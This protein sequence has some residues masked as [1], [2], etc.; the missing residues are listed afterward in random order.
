MNRTLQ[1]GLLALLLAGCTSGWTPGDGRQYFKWRRKGTMP[2]TEPTAIADDDPRLAL[3]W[4]PPKDRPADGSIAPERMA[5]NVPAP[6]PRETDDPD[7]DT[8]VPP[9]TPMKP[10]LVPEIGP[11]GQT[12]YGT[13]PNYSDDEVF[14][15]DDIPA[16]DD[17]PDEPVVADEDEDTVISVAT[18]IDDGPLEIE[19]GEPAPDVESEFATEDV[20]D[21]ELPLG[22]THV[23]A[24][25]M[26]Q[27]NGKFITIED[28]IESIDYQLSNMPMPDSENEFRRRAAGMVDAALRQRVLETLVLSE[29]KA[30]LNEQQLAML[31]A[32]MEEI[33]RDMIAYAGGNEA[34]LNDYY[35]KR[36]TDI[37]AVLRAERNRLIGQ[38]YLRAQIEP[39]IDIGPQELL[40]YYDSHPEE[41]SSP[42]E[43]QM[44]IIAAPYA[45]FLPEGV[46][47]ARST[48]EQRQQAKREARE[49][50]EAV[51]A[52]VQ[53]GDEEFSTLARTYSRG[54][55]ASQDGIWPLMVAGSVREAEV[56]RNAF[57][58]DQGEICGVIQTGTG[59][60][61]VKALVV[62]PDETLSFE[63]AQSKIAGILR[64]EQYEELQ[65]E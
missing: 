34:A 36:G 25:T 33:R 7:G 37:D 16:D 51:A 53:A 61:I 19:Y 45:E 32:Q 18:S 4:T 42:K 44:Q 31:D 13:T 20:E 26:V 3:H 28:V 27:V 10:P 41:F 48:P 23:V 60:Y 2:V 12:R 38:Y 22:P 58:L 47:K 6:A 15:L 43:V 8:P 56:E 14:S 11:A 54:L 52:K 5:P 64:N 65:Q 17:T 40:D 55:M 9:T 1:L 30:N 24:A 63:D 21:E 49:S 57:A 46:S 62:I 29:A 50:I 59:Y 35:R 39:Q